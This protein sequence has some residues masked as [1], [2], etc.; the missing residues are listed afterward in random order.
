MVILQIPIDTTSEDATYWVPTSDGTFLMKSAW[1]IV[2]QRR[3][4][5]QTFSYIWHKSILLTT[6]FFL[7]RLLHDW[8]PVELKMKTKGFQLASRCRCCNSEESLIHV[9]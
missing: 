2:R 6:S 1:E 7:W 4:V 9:M 5:N 8:I 3:V